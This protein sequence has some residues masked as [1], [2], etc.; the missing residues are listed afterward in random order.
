MR[1]GV[2]AAW[3]H[4]SEDN[5]RHRSSHREPIPLTFEGMDRTMASTF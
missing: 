3:R 4:G 5:L 2:V 1:M